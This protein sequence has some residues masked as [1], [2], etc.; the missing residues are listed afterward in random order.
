MADENPK[1]PVP[2]LSA[3]FSFRNEA[4]VIPELVRRMRAV[5]DGERKKGAIRSWELVFVND[6]SSDDS[7]ELLKSMAQG[8]D[9]IKIV[10]MSRR[11]GVSPCA[12][13][14]ME[15][16]T[17]D[18]VVY[19]DADLQDPPEVIPRMID[20]WRAGNGV[21]VVH[22]QRRSRGGESAIKLFSTKVGYHIL[23][24]IASV[25]LPIESGDFKLLT[26]RAVKHLVRLK[27]KNPYLR[28]MVHWIG[29]KQT[30]VIYDREAR[31][32][33]ET[34]FPA[35]SWPVLS[36][37]FEA[38]VISFSLKPLYLAGLMGL[39][40]ALTGFAVLINTLIEYVRG[41]N[42]PGWTAI[43]VAVLFL[44]SFQLLS[45]GVIGLYLG[46]IMLEVK[47]RPNY[48]VKR[49]FGFERNEP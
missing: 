1:L 3:V 40:A 2:S 9:D 41:H 43:M 17:G 35:L 48:I 6:D 36:H 23:R 15:F 47:G 22:T 5:L 46:N 10:T 34:K 21:D 16:S 27:E 33:G 7:E 8:R 13:A 32:A 20:A 45:L 12:L 28:G 49:L 42:I 39:F 18:L 37:F 4:Q 44:G 38:A 25:D 11:Y 30:S 24:R 29:F 31:Q 26:R 19:M 14:G